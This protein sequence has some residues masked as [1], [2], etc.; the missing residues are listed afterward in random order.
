LGAV[1]VVWWPIDLTI[2]AID[3]RRA[4]RETWIGSLFPLSLWSPH[5][6]YDDS[7]PPAYTT[8]TFHRVQYV[9]FTDYLLRLP[10]VD[11]P[12]DNLKP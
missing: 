8:F 5:C 7:R 9:H 6:T 3:A 1:V 2:R 4:F 11:T 12:E 10:V